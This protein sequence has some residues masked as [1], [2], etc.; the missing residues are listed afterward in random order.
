MLLHRKQNQCDKCPVIT[1]DKDL[2]PNADV[3]RNR[4]SV[5]RMVN[6]IKYIHGGSV[7]YGTVS[8]G[9]NLGTTPHI[10]S[11]LLPLRNKF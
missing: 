10:R 3:V 8:T 6:S 1:N 7:T 2:N 9:S 5:H 11:P 4:T